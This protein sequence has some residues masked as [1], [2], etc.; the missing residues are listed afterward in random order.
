MSKLA[1]EASCGIKRDPTDIFIGLVKVDV[2]SLSV[3]KLPKFNLAFTSASVAC[4][5]T[6]ASLFLTKLTFASR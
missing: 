4:S 2:E 6:I 3:L 1:N 5:S